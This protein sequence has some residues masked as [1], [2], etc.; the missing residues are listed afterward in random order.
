MK[1]FVNGDKDLFYRQA[2]QFNKYTHRDVLKYALGANLYMNGKM[3]ILNKICRGDLKEIATITICFE[4]AIKESEIKTCQENTWRMLKKLYMYSKTGELDE[5]K[6][7]L[8]FIRVRNINQFIEFTNKL[9]KDMVKY[10]GGFVFPKFNASDGIMYLEHLKKINQELD[11]KLYGMPILE[12]ENIIYKESRIRELLGIKKVLED[13]K[14][15]ILNIRVGGTDFSSKFGI[16]RSMNSN[17]YSIGVVGECLS[18]IVNIFGRACD[19]YIISAPVWEYFSENERSK[20]VQGILA[21]IALDKENGFMGKTIIHPLQAKYVNG[22]Y[23]VTF[24]EYIDAKD[25]LENSN[26]GGVFKGFGNN[27]MNEVLPHFNWAQHILARAEVFGVL[28]EGVTL[29]DLLNKNLYR[30][31]KIECY[32]ESREVAISKLL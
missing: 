26:E 15:M 30:E 24:E 9:D 18:D 11:E 27:K 2:I 21:E 19:G 3:D 7:P 23:V 4:D 5:D 25:I 14:E 8:I 31:K 13:Y 16:R 20:E 22:S 10:I 28:N 17:I 29:D 1:Y 12:S 32:E 6:I